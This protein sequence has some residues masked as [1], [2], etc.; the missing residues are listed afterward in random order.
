VT[1]LYLNASDRSASERPRLRA[2]LGAGAP[3]EAPHVVGL[4]L[5]RDASPG[6]KLY[7]QDSDV[8]RL[9]SLR[10]VGGA[11]WFGER[12]LAADAHASAA[13][14]RALDRVGKARPRDFFVAIGTGTGGSAEW[15][16]CDVPVW[17]GGRA[18]ALR[19]IALWP[20][21][22]FGMSLADPV[23]HT[24]HFK[25]PGAPLP[26]RLEPAPHFRAAEVRVGILV[27]TFAAPPVCARA[28]RHA[29]SSWAREGEP[30]GK[31]LVVVMRWSRRRVEDAEWEGRPPDGALGGASPPPPWYA[32]AG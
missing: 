29:V 15:M 32:V 19:P 3:V 17:D 4:N 25:P 22:S 24:M 28:A 1:K 9:A 30:D 20:V 26:S 7:R 21:R 2:Q 8:A 13:L 16:L 12:T 18:R 10:G 23:T 11:A 14:S 31:Q 5:R 27:E 6:V